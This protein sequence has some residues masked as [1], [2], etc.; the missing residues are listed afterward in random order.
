MVAGPNTAPHYPFVEAAVNAVADWINRYRRLAGRSALGECDPREVAR[1]AAELGISAADLR[2][3][4][5]AKPG[6]ADLLKEMLPALGFDPKTLA[7]TDPLVMRDLQRL[8]VR[9]RNKSECRHALDDLTA[10]ERYHEFCPNA[11][12]LEALLKERTS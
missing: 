9:C 2:D 4:A 1:I 3:L 10:S 7:E 8:C 11:V 12:T 6:S 5:E